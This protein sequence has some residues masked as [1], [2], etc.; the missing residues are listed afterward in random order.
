MTTSIVTL[1]LSTIFDRGKV[2]L[3]SRVRKKLNVKDG[4]E[5]VFLEYII[6]PELKAV[7][8]K[9]NVADQEKARFA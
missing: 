5:V 8:V 6:P 2:T 9:S 3:P 4:D 7:V 1:G